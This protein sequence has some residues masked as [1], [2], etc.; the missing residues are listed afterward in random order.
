[1]A[2]SHADGPQAVPAEKRVQVPTLPL[3][4]QLSQLP[5]HDR[6]QHTP[7]AQNVLAQSIRSAHGAPIFLGPGVPTP[8]PPTAP[9][10]AVPD[11]EAPPAPLAPTVE[12]A[13]PRPAAPVPPCPPGVTFAA[14][15]AGRS[16]G[17]RPHAT[18]ATRQPAA[19]AD[20]T[21]APGR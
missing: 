16:M 2:P 20:L 11:P 21:D 5:S 4:A 9:V 1:V 8:D 6:S 15:T 12:P 7:L 3:C 10:P 18:S 17:V 13:A 14:P 19:N